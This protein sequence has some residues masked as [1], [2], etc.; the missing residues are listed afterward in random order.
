M[1]SFWIAYAIAFVA[2]WWLYGFVDR[3]MN[4]AGV[5][6]INATNPHGDPQHSLAFKLTIGKRILFAILM[7]AALVF[8]AGHYPSYRNWCYGLGLLWSVCNGLVLGVVG[9]VVIVALWSA[10]V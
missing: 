5:G 9:L 8:L 7:I 6:W 1:M 4:D 3:I 2:W 10:G